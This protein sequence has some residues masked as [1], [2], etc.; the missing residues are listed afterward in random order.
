MISSDDPLC[1]VLMA[2]HDTAC[3]CRVFII[4]GNSEEHCHIGIMG[5]LKLNFASFSVHSHYKAFKPQAVDDGLLM[6]RGVVP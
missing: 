1:S 3:V 6:Y 5:V 4:L 2:Q